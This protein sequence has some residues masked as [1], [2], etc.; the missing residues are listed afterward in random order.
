MRGGARFSDDRHYRYLLSRSWV[1]KPE[2][3]IHFLMLNPS[4]ADATTN[5]PTIRRCISFARRLRGHGLLVTNIYA[6]RATDPRD[7]VDY[8]DP[9]GPQN[10]SYISSCALKADITIAA[11]GNSVTKVPG[12]NDRIIEV[13]FCIGYPWFRPLYCFGWTAKGQPRHPLMLPTDVK[14]LKV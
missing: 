1:D 8:P 9:V 6:K 11:W 7:L 10:N 5:D 12:Y 2:N 4:T 14:L 3:W 13:L